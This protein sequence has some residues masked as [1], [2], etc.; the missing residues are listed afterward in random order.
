MRALLFIVLGLSMCQGV[1]LAQ[2]AG[3]HGGDAEH[4][5]DYLVQRSIADP[6]AGLLSFILRLENFSQAPGDKSR[7][8]VKDVFRG[9]PVFHLPREA[10][11]VDFGTWLL[12]PRQNKGRVVE[13]NHHSVL[14]SWVRNGLGVG[15]NTYRTEIIDQRYFNSR[16][17]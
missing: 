3:G 9:L 13:L 17:G 6:E 11:N 5:G 2:S 7:P 15:Q 8:W 1:G 4:G 14:R 16:G 12:P 10:H